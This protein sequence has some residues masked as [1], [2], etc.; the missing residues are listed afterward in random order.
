MRLEPKYEIA[1]N[2]LGLAFYDLGKLDEAMI[3]FKKA[4]EIKPDYAK[5]RMNIGYAKI[6]K[7]ATDGLETLEAALNTAPLDHINRYRLGV[8]LLDADKFPEAI[9]AFR[10]SI[11]LKPD[12]INARLP[13][14]VALLHT[15]QLDECI[16]ELRSYIEKGSA[17]P[18]AHDSLGN[19]LLQVRGGNR[20]FSQGD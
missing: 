1:Q 10:K 15:G 5:A 12:Y 4:L 18:E 19:A 14:G 8:A 13:L 11:E 16:T 20:I 17:N 3:H 2:N 7:G 9:T 6:K